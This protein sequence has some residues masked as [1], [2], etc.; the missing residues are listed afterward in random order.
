M[1]KVAIVGDLHLG[2]SPNNSLKFEVIFESQKSFFRECLIPE[3]KSRGIKKIIFTGDLYDQRRRVDSQITQYVE[4]L[5]EKEL[6]E[7][8]CIIIQ[9]NH[10]TYYKDELTITSLSNIWS[11]SNVTVITKITPKEIYN[12]KFL[13]VPWLTSEL[14]TL[15]VENASK[16]SGKFEYVIGHFETVGFQY[17]AGNI[18]VSGL[19]PEIFYKNFKNTISGHFHTQS[20]KEVNG[21]S[22][23]Y[24]GTPF[25]LTFGDTGETKGF[26]ILDVDTNKREFIEN[27]SSSKFIRIKGRA[28]LSK[29]ETLKN[30]FVELKYPEGTTDDELFIIE[31]EA[32][33]KEP[34]TYK[35]YLMVADKLEDL[36]S[37]KSEEEIKVFEDMS[38]AIN[39]ENMIEMTKVFLQAQKYDDPEMVLELI[40]D[41]RAKIT[42]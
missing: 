29:Y 2:V 13:F 8:E 18:S 26:T 19:D 34:I 15:F 1:H 5:F 22:I 33:A 21:N 9:G 17:E 40:L 12:K 4:E 31:K 35:A 24:V 16:A 32:M 38:T 25:Q 23:H 30:C 20:Y 28:E 7:F 11:K 14:E 37:D 27:T 10:D 6:K 42:G 36:I 39:S 3:L 41:I